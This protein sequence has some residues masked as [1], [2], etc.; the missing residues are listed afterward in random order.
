MTGVYSLD[1][2]TLGKRLH[3][4]KVDQTVISL[5]ISPTHGH[6]LVGL[7]SRRVHA[8]SRPFPMA[9]I[10]K[11]IDR[12]AEED[13]AEKETRTPEARED[14]V[15]D[16]YMPYSFES[17]VPSFLRNPRVHSNRYA[18]RTDEDQKDSQ[19]SMVLLRE[20]QQVNRETAGYMSLNCIR[21]VPQA[22]QGI[23]YATNTGQL[24]ILH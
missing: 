21:W 19:K 4:T 3:S 20:L 13:S 5:S 16:Q 1:W 7:A 8:P 15:L 17:Y 10:Y 9:L 11:F 22:G 23:I 6:L 12:P 2:E 18:A 24:N 14:E